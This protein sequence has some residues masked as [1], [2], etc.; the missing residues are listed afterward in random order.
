M[1]LIVSDPEEILKITRALSVMSRI[2]ILKLVADNE[3]NVT[4]L[5]EILHMTKA[6][7]SMHISELE[8]AGLIEVTYKNGVKGIKKVIK[9]KYDKIIIDLNSSNSFQET[10]KDGR[11]S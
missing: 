10:N 9:L 7:V 4:E 2:N 1:E 5:S 8:N 6:N 3:L 11:R